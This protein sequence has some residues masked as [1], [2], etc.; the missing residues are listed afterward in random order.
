MSDP[1]RR[2]WHELTTTDFESLG[3]ASSIA[4]LPVAAVEQHGPHL[5]LDVDAC[6]NAG[7]LAAT[8]DRLPREIPLV[9]LPPQAVGWSDEHGRFPGTL[10][11]SAEMLIR[12][13]CEIGESVAR[14]G[15]RK[16]VLFNSHGG[17]TEIVK[18][19]TR[20]L[21]IAHGMLAVGVN[22]FSLADISAMFGPDERKY[23]IH[24]GAA[25]TS[26]MLHLRP[27]LVCED[28]LADFASSAVEMSEKFQ[29]LGPTGQVSFGWETQDLNL[30]GAV[31]N[32]L[33]AS[34]EKGC[35]FVEQVADRFVE[36]LRE[37]DAFDLDRL[38]TRDAESGAIP[39][40]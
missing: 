25:E 37:I 27:D 30:S 18:I 4:L 10:S 28:A 20:K 19:V 31:G 2:Y 34:A 36:V 33:A 38:K 22:W 29:H 5:P 21:R 16:F 7:I 3:Q 17:Q 23:G 40:K 35:A 14:A 8:L 6:I 26:V 15:I 12:V 11:L 9:V 24:G 39:R 32:A 1:P 13:W